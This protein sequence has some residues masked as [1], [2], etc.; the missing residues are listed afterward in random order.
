[1]DKASL[2]KEYLY[3]RSQIKNRDSKDE[4]I[5]NKLISNHHFK[6]A[7]TILTYVSYRDEVDT[8][9][10]IKYAL[11]N[12]KR[13]ATPK[14]QNNELVFY[15]IHSFDDL[16]KGTY[17]IMEPVGN[18]IASDMDAIS[19]TPALCYTKDGYRLGYGGGYYDRYYHNHHPYKIGLCYE[20]CLVDKIPVE[21]GDEKVDM[22][23]TSR[24]DDENAI[25][26]R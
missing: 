21:I 26:S 1:M 18:E 9:K 5:Y 4:E 19:L 8:Y 25:I 14:V 17:G 3:I 24:K 2:R 10:I 16:K 22:I 11:E 15:Y 7:K 23:I 6:K 13:V 12:G 20:D